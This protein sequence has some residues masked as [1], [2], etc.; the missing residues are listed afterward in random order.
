M[1]DPTRGAKLLLEAAVTMANA[2]G[3][4]AIVV[5]VDAL[6]EIDAVPANTIL[7]ARDDHDRER[8][9]KLSGTMKATIDVPEVEL[10]RMGQVKLHAIIS[11]SNRYID[12]QDTVIFLAG[13]YRSLIDSLVVMTMGVEYELFDTTDQPTIDEHI[14][15]AV[16]HRVLSIALNLGQHG[17]EGKKV[18]AMFVVGDIRSVMDMSEQMILNP[19]K[20]YSEKVRNVLDDTMGETVK[21]YSTLDG[22]IIIR[23]NGVIETAGARLKAGLSDGLPSG[24][25]ARHATAA[26]ITASTRSIAFTVSE[27]DGTVRVWRAGKM[28]ASFEPS[29]R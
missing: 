6:P 19:F 5:A 12:L 29:Q 13:P 9:K 11:I 20:G 21:E 14:K 28:V 3:A 23:G 26:G 22:A 16:F 17:R 15:R 18:G 10:N 7:V 27:S 2:V 4:K 25:G 8:I 24:L 1:N